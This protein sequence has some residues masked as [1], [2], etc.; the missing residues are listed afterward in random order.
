MGSS[1]DEWGRLAQI[2]FFDPVSPMTIR[3]VANGYQPFQGHPAD[4]RV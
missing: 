4:W 3:R 2:P 1:S